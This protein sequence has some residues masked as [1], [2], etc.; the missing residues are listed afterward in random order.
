M[1]YPTHH[2][3]SNMVTE[4][5][6]INAT[7]TNVTGVN[8]GTMTT[9]SKSVL[10]E[11]TI[12]KDCT[13][14]GFDTFLLLQSD[15]VTLTNLTHQNVN[16]TGSALNYYVHMAMNEGGTA[17]LNSV[18][19]YNCDLEQKPG[20]HFEGS[21]TN[22]ILTN[23][24]FSGVKVGTSNAIINAIQVS[25]LTFTNCSFTGIDSSSATDEGNLMVNIQSFGLSNAANS[26]IKG[27]T[28]QSSTISFLEFN[29]IQGSLYQPVSI[30]FTNMIF[31]DCAFDVNIDIVKFGN[32]ETQENITFGFSGMYFS[33]MTFSGS[34]SL[35]KFQH[36]LLNEITVR[37]SNFTSIQGGELHVEAANKQNLGSP[38]KVRL[39]NCKF[40]DIDANYD[41]LMRANEGA[42]VNIEH[43]TFSNIYTLEEGSVIFA[44]YQKAIVNITNSTFT[45]NHA[46]TGGV[47]NVENESVI[48]LYDCLINSNFA[49]T[50][51]VFHATN[52][53]Y[54][55]V[56]DSI[57]TQ[58]YA[59]SSSVSQIFDSATS[60]VIDNTSIYFNEGLTITE[61]ENEMNIN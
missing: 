7:F 24:I 38:T 17:N 30:M 37:N 25:T 60:S 15:T 33:N 57:I 39:S 23:T 16:G 9:L 27:I 4:I 20:L 22:L 55:E 51:G 3:F 52:F 58:N 14:F 56:Y 44:G 59:I 40:S 2:V 1:P 53:G 32:L 31:R 54:Y 11:N 18:H 12:Y 26:V 42:V 29:S 6:I 13:D 34:G 8:G 46:L 10:V 50:S 47:F 45:S 43:S 41:S 5:Q 35:L 61:L 28:V 36:Q 19:F 49:V 48:K 21:V